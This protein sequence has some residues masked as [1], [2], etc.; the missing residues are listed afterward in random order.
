MATI[1]MKVKSSILLLLSVLMLSASGQDFESLQNAFS[2]SYAFEAD[3]E[4]SK[5]INELKQVYNEDSYGINLRLGWLFYLSAEYTES[6]TFYEQAIQLKPYSV[7]AKF[8]YT[9]PLSVLGNW[10]QVK[11]QY[12]NI[13]EIDPMNS[14]ANYQ[15]GLMYY[16]IEDY[17]NAFK[18]FEKVVN[19]YP[20][21]YDGTHMFAWTHYRLGKL[22]EAEVLFKKALLIRPGDVSAL[23]GLRLVE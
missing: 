3:K 15:L 12:L 21:D 10:S 13:L 1:N 6:L 17:S 11:T 7:E 18:H 14:V 22:R 9:Y 8:G 20:I 2:Q 4:Y 16:N 19:Q 23:E 5:A